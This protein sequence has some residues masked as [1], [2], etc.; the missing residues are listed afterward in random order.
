M[1]V[2]ED[3]EAGLV[4]EELAEACEE[5]SPEDTA[6]APE[7]SGVPR[8]GARLP[9]IGGLPNPHLGPMVVVDDSGF[10][11]PIYT[12]SDLLRSFRFLWRTSS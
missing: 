4:L 9:W 1:T 6:D 11:V 5:I 10:L 7:R 8:H 2:I 12:A 3:N